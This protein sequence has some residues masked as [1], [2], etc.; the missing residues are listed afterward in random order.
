MHQ[1]QSKMCEDLIIHN[2]PSKDSTHDLTPGLPL[3]SRDAAIS[4]SSK[5][6][7]SCVGGQAIYTKLTRLGRVEQVCNPSTLRGRGRKILSSR[8]AEQVQGM[9]GLHGKIL[10]LKK[11]KSE[12]NT[13]NSNL[14]K[15]LS[16][17]PS[18]RTELR[19]KG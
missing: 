8:S 14:R 18:E 1:Y 5:S 11:K 10:C 17:I 12:K 9:H 7:L 4:P 19:L 15:L 2:F 6:L 3:G 16:R 13:T